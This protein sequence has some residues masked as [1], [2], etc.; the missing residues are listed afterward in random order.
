MDMVLLGKAK[1]HVWPTAQRVRRFRL[2]FRIIEGR[3]KL[4][5]ENAEGQRC[6]V[7]AGKLEQKNGWIDTCKFERHSSG[8]R[9]WHSISA[10]QYT[11]FSD[12][13]RR[14]V[15]PVGDSHTLQLFSSFST[16][17]RTILVSFRR[18]RS[19]ARSESEAL[20]ADCIA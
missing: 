11:V 1:W 17:H 2:L 18:G 19:S 14:G 20:F 7:G 3:Y 5:A 8:V 9:K 12:H 6:Y 15:F 13:G 10:E 4:R 16:R